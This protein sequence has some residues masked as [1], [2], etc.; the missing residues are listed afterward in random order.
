[1]S[2]DKSDRDNTI[3]P[4]DHDDAWLEASPVEEEEEEDVGEVE[5]IDQVTV[6]TKRTA[7]ED[8]RVTLLTGTFF[9]LFGTVIAAYAVAVWGSADDWDRVSQLLQAI[10]PVETLILGAA[11]SYY[12]KTD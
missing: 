4:G 1:M 9:L 6:R 11:V 5:D 10:I 3:E 7:D 12:F 2:H 8:A